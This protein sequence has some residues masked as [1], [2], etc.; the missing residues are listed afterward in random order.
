VHQRSIDVVDAR[1]DLF[2]RCPRLLVRFHPWIV[3]KP[4]R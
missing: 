1:A 2:E 4:S 3:G